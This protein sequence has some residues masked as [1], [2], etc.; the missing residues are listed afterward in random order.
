MS[1]L[2]PED[3]ERWLDYLTP[4]IKKDFAPTPHTEQELLRE[5]L[6]DYLEDYQTQVETLTSDIEKLREGGIEIKDL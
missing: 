3:V 1:V 4:G 5:L 6:Q 2:Q